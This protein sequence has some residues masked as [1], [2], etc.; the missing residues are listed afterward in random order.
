MTA[1]HR[2]LEHRTRPFVAL[3]LVALTA[4]TL[5]ACGGDDGD[6]GGSGGG[7]TADARTILR[8]TFSG[9]HEVRSADVDLRLT[10]AEAGGGESFTVG[11]GGPFETDGDRELP[12][13][14]MQL[15]ADLG[16]QGQFRAGLVSVDERLFVEWQD[17]AYEVPSQLLD[18]ARSSFD[19]Q[20]QSQRGQSLEAYGIDP[21]SWIDDPEV[22]GQEDVGG[23]ETDRVS[24]TLNVKAFLDSVDTLLAEVDRQGLAAASGQD[25]P[26]RIPADDRAEI[27]RT[28]RDARVDVWS[29]TEDRTL[30]K[31]QVGL[32]VQPDGERG[33][34]VDF[35]LQ[36]DGVNEPQSIEAPASSRPIDELL[37]QF[38]GLLGGSP[39][40]G[41]SSSGGGADIDAYQDCLV[42]AAGDVEAAQR[43]ASLL[44]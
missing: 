4:L 39:L 25:V 27:E 20:S 19:Q 40:G 13:F 12:S 43:C 10:L 16:A 29:G 30:R 14:D 34:T 2:A 1:I 8:E 24:G 7:D 18:Q 6:G 28:I 44:R 42:R 31:L 15:D 3:L 22:V 11:I 36:L 9:T 17:Q 32:G 21:Q 33:G 23:T 37:G 26:D 35:V 41:G 5:A 38:Q